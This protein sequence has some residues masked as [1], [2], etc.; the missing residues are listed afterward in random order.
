MQLLMQGL[1]L[2]FQHTNP[3]LISKKCWLNED[4]SKRLNKKIKQK[5]FTKSFHLNWD[6]AYP[7]LI[8]RAKQKNKFFNKC[9]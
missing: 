2:K 5:E 3:S 8:K 1:I 6:L 7:K 9:I 4:Q